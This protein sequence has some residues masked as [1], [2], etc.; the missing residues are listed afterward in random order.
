[1]SGG[2][3]R[4][5][6]SKSELEK[7]GKDGNAAIIGELAGR[8]MSNDT[9][10]SVVETE[11]AA[12]VLEAI[13]PEGSIFFVDLATIPEAQNFIFRNLYLAYHAD[14][15]GKYGILKFN[16][17]VSIEEKREDVIR[18]NECYQGWKRTILYICLQT[19]YPL[20]EVSKLQELKDLYNEV[21]IN[22]KLAVF[23]KKN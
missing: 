19:F 4:K 17:V 8:L 21:F 10:L 11:F 13:K 15:E 7:I 9:T 12:S 6:Y 5:R 1:M 2:K 3:K 22:E 23:I 20:E 18:L 16:G 14:L